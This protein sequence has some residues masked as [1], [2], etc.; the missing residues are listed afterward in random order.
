MQFRPARPFCLA[1]MTAILAVG[2]TVSDEP[3]NLTGLVTQCDSCHAPEAQMTSLAPVLNGLPRR[4]LE[5]Q[6]GYFQSGQRGGGDTDS[7]TAGMVAQLATLSAAE[8]GKLVRHYAAQTRIV[9]RQTVPGNV[10][11]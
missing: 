11:A 9:S 8:T 6:I 1:I 3:D 5:E 2:C 4:Y 10:A 7:P